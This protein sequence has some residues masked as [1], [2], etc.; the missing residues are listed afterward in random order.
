M[1]A[2][3]D[4]SRWLAPTVPVVI[5]GAVLA[6]EATDGD[7]VEGL[8]WFAVLAAAGALLAF[9]GAFESVR[10]ARG[11]GEDE[12]EAMLGERAMA[13]AGLVLIIALTA[14]IVFQ[15]ARGDD[16]SPYTYLAAIG[17]ASYAAAL[18]VLHRRS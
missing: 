16:P 6:A 15:V 17:G 11:D 9:G 10:L 5:G 18:V 2:R 4:R 7:L 8:V 12:R 3:F 1:T 14:V 13:A